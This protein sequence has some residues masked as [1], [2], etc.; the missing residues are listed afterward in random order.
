MYYYDLRISSLS[1]LVLPYV[2]DYFGG[3]VHVARV[4]KWIWV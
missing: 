2:L 1:R 4:M 3:N